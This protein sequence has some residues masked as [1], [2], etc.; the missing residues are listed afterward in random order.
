MKANGLTIAP[1]RPK[2]LSRHDSILK[3]EWLNSKEHISP[4]LNSSIKITLVHSCSD[5]CS[6]F[7]VYRRPCSDYKPMDKLKIK[8]R[9]YNTNLPCT[10]GHLNGSHLNTTCNISK[11]LVVEV[12]WQCQG[13]GFTFDIV[14]NNVMLTTNNRS[15]I[16]LKSESK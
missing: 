6:D 3:G 7:S 9:Y 1:L 4:Y 12:I 11:C 2:L 8:T 13:W 10:E 16:R 14:I 5:T 15:Y